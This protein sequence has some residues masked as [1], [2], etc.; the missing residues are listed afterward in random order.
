M[1]L[2]VLRRKLFNLY[3]RKKTK[4]LTQIPLFIMAFDYKKFKAE[5][6]KNSC[7]LHIHPE[8]AEDKFVKSKLQEVVDYVR[9]NYD[10]DIFTKI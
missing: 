6:K 8:L 9:G 7:M 2:S 10:M 1:N 4:N 5:G 3:I